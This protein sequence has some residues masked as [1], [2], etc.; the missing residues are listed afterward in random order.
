MNVKHDLE[1]ARARPAVDQAA[2]FERDLGWLVQAMPGV[3]YRCSFNEAGG[4]T[5]HAMTAR[6]TDL[7]G[8]PAEGFIE[9][10]ARSWVSVIHPDDRAHALRELR[11]ILERSSGK[12]DEVVYRVITAAGHERWLEQQAWIVRDERGAAT[13]LRGFLLD[14]TDQHRLLQ[15]EVARN[16]AY[17]RQKRAMV[18]LVTSASLAEGNIE[19]FSVLATEQVSVGVDVERASVWLFNDART[20]LELADLYLRTPARHERGSALVASAYPTYFAALASG[21]ALD[22]N[23]AAHDPRTCEFAADYL[24]NNGIVAMLDAAV[25][26]GGEVVGAVCL[27]HTQT[28]RIWQRH[29]I[30]FV[31]EVADQLSLALHHRAQRRA[32]AR[33]KLLQE[34]LLHSQKMDAL[35]RLAGGVAHDFNNLLMMIS[36]SAEL[37]EMRLDDPTVRSLSQDIIR[38]CTRA[39]ELTEQLRAF[40]RQ[41][42]LERLDLDLVQVVAKL[43]RM[44]RRTLGRGVRLELNLPD[45]PVVVRATEQLLQQ[46]VT[47]LVVNAGEAVRHDRKD[48]GRVEIMVDVVEFT[49]PVTAELPEA[50]PPGRYASVCVMDDGR[51]MTPEVQARAF[52]PFFTTKP[53]GEGTGLGLATVYS[54]ARRCEGTVKVASE[55][56]QG[57]QFFVLLPLVAKPPSVQ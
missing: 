12:P 25:R 30:E 14:V 27:E 38:A 33:E 52:E 21:R 47:N 49:E 8:Y 57:S 13:Q 36:G 39:S 28:P 16:S 31:A 42:P 45:E 51:G 4:L 7:L 20:Q 54:I 48:P 24:P 55:P 46:M 19:D 15:A 9:D 26:V 43:E 23:D 6:V 10:A 22:A 3:A 1:D 37:L 32:A 41:Q 11:A 5:M 53:D 34:Q 50:V 2:G 44:L 40:S 35:G 56:G 29:E 18:T 17:E